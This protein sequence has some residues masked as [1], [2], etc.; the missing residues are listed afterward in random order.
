MIKLILSE[1][2]KVRAY[3][4]IAIENCKKLFPKLKYFTS[5]YDAASGAD[6][7]IIITEWNE[8]KFL[9]LEKLRE[10]MAQ[11]IIFDGRNIFDPKRV[12]DAGFKYYSIG[13]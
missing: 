8:F 6:A 12:T 1:G 3:D 13:R 7:I 9:A 4:P 2:A 10:V 5:P 11:P